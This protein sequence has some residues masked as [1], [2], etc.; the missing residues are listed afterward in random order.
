M[1]TRLAPLSMIRA[2]DTISTSAKRQ[3]NSE[4][5][6]GCL[7]V[8]RIHLLGGQRH[9]G[10]GRVEVHAPV[11]RNFVGG[12]QIAGPTLDSAERAALDTGYLDKPGNRIAGHAEM[13]FQRAL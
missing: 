3:G 8:F 4:A 6:F 1:A 12:D 2:V 11:F 7:L 10:N 13:M 9:G 5:S